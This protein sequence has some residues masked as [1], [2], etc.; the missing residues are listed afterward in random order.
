MTTRL[1]KACTL[2]LL[3]FGFLAAT[4]KVS[5][6]ALIPSSPQEQT[7]RAIRSIKDAFL[8]DGSGIAQPAARSS[9][10]RLYVDYLI[11]LPEETKAGDIDPW[12]GG[13]A[14]VYPYAEDIVKEILA[15]CC[16]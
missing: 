11:P 16:R 13:L 7:R 15:A 10:R 5:A 1:G 3:L 2:P 4:A 9:S 12:P 8:Q 6:A 14:Q